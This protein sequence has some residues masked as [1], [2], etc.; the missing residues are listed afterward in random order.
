[1]N[2]D[3]LVS[4][5]QRPWQPSAAAEDVDV[6]DKFDFPTSGTYRLGPDLVLF[7]LITAAGARSLW[8][9]VPVPRN[10]AAK[11]AAAR[12]YSDQEFDHFVSDLFA[13]REAVFAAAQD[14]VIDGKSDGV[15]IDMGLHALLEAAAQWYI[16]TR[17][18][19]LR[20]ETSDAEDLLSATQGLL[21]A[22]PV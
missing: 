4:S 10:E 2:L 3:T 9:Y 13:G 20:V 6:W 16:T 15:R 21:A 5:G 22:S 1:M 7:R 14:F 19:A 11:V 12:F 8:A 18:P 17:F